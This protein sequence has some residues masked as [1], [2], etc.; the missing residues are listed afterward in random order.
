MPI[1]DPR[2]AKTGPKVRENAYYKRV[3]ADTE[4]RAGHGRGDVNT[5]SVEGFFGSFKRSMATYAHCR[6]KYLGRYV[7]EAEFRY[8]TRTKPGFSDK[9]RAT[10]AIKGAVGKRLTLR[11]AQSRQSA[12]ATDGRH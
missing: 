11:P 10:L 1:E 9:E 12:E 3:C 4:A 2:Y 8:N 5:N 6:E 7:R